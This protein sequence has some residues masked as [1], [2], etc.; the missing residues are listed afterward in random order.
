MIGKTS[1]IKE[2]AHIGKNVRIGEFCIIGKNVRIGDDCVIGNYVHIS[3]HTTLGKGNKVY[4]NAAVG[5]PPQDLKYAGEDTELIIGDEN[6]IREFTTLNPGTAGGRR[7]T[8]I[9]NRNLLMAYVHIAHDCII[10]NDCI[11]ANNATLAGHVELGDFVNIGG[12]T[13]IHQFCKIGD[14]CMIA[15][16]AVLTQDAPPYCL[17]EGNRAYIRGLNKHRMRKLFSREEIDEI[18]RVY[19]ILFSHSAP[20]RE[21]AQAQLES[22]PIDSIRYICEF[23]LSSTRGIPLKGAS[24]E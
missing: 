24:N 21:L 5:V 10:G 15:G 4:N 20:I 6:L 1:I 23:I 19:K 13:P 16:G 17:L 8:T 7:K 3:G 2:G 9:G 12:L 22:S 18:S 14:G 11:L